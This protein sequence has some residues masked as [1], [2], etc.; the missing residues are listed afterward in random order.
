M[1]KRGASEIDWIISM[2]IFL[3]Y[4]GWFFAFVLPQVNVMAGKD[5]S[6]YMLK[7]AFYERNSWSMHKFP[8]FVFS[9]TTGQFIPAIADYEMNRTD[10][11]MADRRTFELWNG[12]LLFLAD[13]ETSPGVYYLLD[14][15]SFQDEEQSEGLNIVE[16]WLSTSN[17]S[18]YFESSLPEKIRYKDDDR[19]DDISFLINGVLIDPL[20]HSHSNFGFA[21]VF[22]YK[23][24][25]LN[26]TTFV[27]QHNPDVLMHISAQEDVTYSMVMRM[28][29]DNYDSYFSDNNNFGDLRYSNLSQTEIFS[30][31]YITL[32]GDD[33][34]SIYFNDTADINLTY[35]NRTLWMAADFTIKDDDWIKLSFHEGDFGDAEEYS[36]S[37]AYG[38]VEELEGLRLEDFSAD[39]DELKQAWGYDKEFY[40]AIYENTTSLSYQYEP[41]YVIGKFD[42]KEGLVYAED[43]DYLALTPEGEMRP[44]RVNFRIW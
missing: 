26:I 44:V 6:M 40:I 42:P 9:N 14:G 13:I 33:A 10:L 25:S 4:I 2:S 35:Y 41:S 24:G 18:V 32:Y 39:Y 36:T 22:E 28:K 7:D 31:D 19:A 37:Y 38:A 43:V 29:L 8:V 15:G 12:R 17:L 3:L 27:F 5:A 1:G 11:H 23:T 34:L 16:D 21:G 30:H 20:N